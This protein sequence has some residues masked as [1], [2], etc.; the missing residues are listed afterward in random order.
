[1]RWDVLVK[2]KKPSMQRIEFVKGPEGDARLFELIRAAERGV[3]AGVFHPNDGSMWCSGCP[4]S[5]A[6]TTWQENPNA[7]RT[8]S[9]NE[10]S[11]SAP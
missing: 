8:N 5:K 9:A 7:F 1:M 11:R 2:T 3:R 10:L 6:C 4:F